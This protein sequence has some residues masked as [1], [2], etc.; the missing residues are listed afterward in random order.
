M[1]VSVIV[2]LTFHAYILFAFPG[3]TY[4]AVSN[5]T[6][7]PLSTTY[8]P[9]S[10]SD[11]DVAVFE[12]DV[13]AA[14][15]TAYDYEAKVA[16]AIGH[17]GYLH[18]VAF[19]EATG[20]GT[21]AKSVRVSSNRTTAVDACGGMV[22]VTIWGSKPGQDGTVMFYGSYDRDSS[23]L[24]QLR[25]QTVGKNPSALKFSRDCKTLVVA[26]QGIADWTDADD[27]SSFVNP[28]GSVTIISN[29]VKSE[30][31]LTYTV[32]T[33][34]F[35]EFNSQ[36]STLLTQG[37][38]FVMRKDSLNNTY[39]LAQDLQ[40]DAVAFTSDQ[41]MVY[42]AIQDNNAIA[43][44]NLASATV[45]AIY[46]LG[47]KDFSLE[48]NAIDT[49]DNKK[50][51]ITM[52][53]TGFYCLFQPDDITAFSEGGS[54]YVVTANEGDS[55][56]YELKN[57]LLFTEEVE[58]SFF[59]GKLTQA[60]NSSLYTRITAGGDLENLRMSSAI[61]QNQEDLYERIYALEAAVFRSTVTTRTG[62]LRYMTAESC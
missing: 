5:V 53:P 4:A 25:Q 15:S 6:L 52:K 12:L 59:V 44:V 28:E 30:L 17:P 38:H 32:K 20:Q 2:P 1:S 55:R 42:V 56:E 40:P 48:N 18:V 9:S 41:S 13:D 14:D 8:V 47:F 36:V 33:A 49:N 10:F 37:L 34:D 46:G 43:V 3:H 27:F 50:V 45:T 51:E 16:Y 24:Q 61:G 23:S 11:A 39:T 26:N 7:R 54:R 60:A 22:A 21:V 57:Q 58:G 19:N 62:S 35:K 29:I 31:T